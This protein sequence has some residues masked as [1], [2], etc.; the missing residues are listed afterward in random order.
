MAEQDE[1]DVIIHGCNCFCNWGKGIA[2]QMKEHFPIAYQADKKTKHGDGSKLGGVATVYDKRYRL[3]IVNAYTQYGYG[4]R[5]RNVNYSAI[6]T[7][8]T[9]I[10][11]RFRHCP[12]TRIG[13]PMIGAGLASGS[14]GKISKIIDD[15]LKGLNHTLVIL[16]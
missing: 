14:W 1:L 3:I 8:F 12:S 9:L 7:C 11:R 5:R 16:P 4:G 2:Q 10:A 15:R 13:Y 6:D